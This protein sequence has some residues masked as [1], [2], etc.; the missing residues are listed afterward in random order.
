MKILFKLVKVIFG[1]LMTL[2]IIILILVIVYLT[3]FPKKDSICVN[4]P[5][6]FIITKP[7]VFG[8]QGHNECAAY[9]AAYVL[10]A[11]EKNVN[12]EII[13]KKMKNKVPFLGVVPSKGIV[14][15]LKRYDIKATYYKGDINTLKMRVSKDKPVILYVGE[16]IKWEHF[17]TVVG[18]DNSSSV[19]YLYDSLLDNDLNAGE[20]GNRTLTE[21][22]LLKIWDNGLPILN[23]TYI[24]VDE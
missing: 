15:T 14:D 13:Y 7:N 2:F 18:Y 3:P 8:T 5:S 20:P 12:G 19:I 9:A 24:A 6:R 23:H 21:D 11:F 22:E 4:L 16:N 10:R 17:I 1:L